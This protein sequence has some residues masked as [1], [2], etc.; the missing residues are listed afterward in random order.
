[1][2]G[3]FKVI[4]VVFILILL[5]G[6]FKKDD[7]DGV[8]KIELI[9]N[10]TQISADNNENVI[11]TIKNYDKDGNEIEAD[12]KLYKNGK[13]LDGVTFSTSEAGIYTFT[14]KSG[15][16]VSN[17]I[18]VSAIAPFEELYLISNESLDGTIYETTGNFLSTYVKLNGVNR[19]KRGGKGEKI[20][21]NP[22]LEFNAPMLNNYI[23]SFKKSIK[24][25]AGESKSFYIYNFQSDNMEKM[26]AKLKYIGNS[27]EVWTNDESL[28]NTEEAQKL[29]TEFDNVISPLVTQN[30]YTPSDIDGNGKVEIL[31]YDIKD[32]YETTGSYVGGYFY[33][34][35]LMN[36]Y[37]GNDMEIF[38]ID[39]YP[40]MYDS[41]NKFNIKYSYETLVH[42]F[43]HM[44]NF[45][46]VYFTD[47]K[48]SSVEPL[49]LNEGL[50][51]AA[52]QI[53][54]GSVLDYRINYY[55]H[56]P[57]GLIRDGY[58]MLDWNNLLEDYS[59]SYLFIQYIKEQT[60]MGDSALKE[61]FDDEN[62]NYKSIEKVAQKYIRSDITFGELMTDYRIAMLKKENS[63][64][65]G[66]NGTA[67]FEAINTPV[68][69]GGVKN[70][71]GG[72]AVVVP[73]A[74]VVSVPTDSGENI[75]YIKIT[76]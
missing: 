18:K 68:Y 70:I 13:V 45:N 52:E 48:S 49:W 14:A 26:S 28:I 55:N 38:Y 64:L 24:Y 67:G 51:Q 16:V 53:Y 44:V 12:S 3:K 29:A 31:C 54:R 57:E 76:K 33:D 7:K 19:L 4:S 36:S 69:S 11:F 6:C 37:Y 59:L 56:D 75:K 47:G 23:D 62:H 50:S 30:F 32:D 43:Q 41:N 73:I 17:E 1:M 34:A 2:K 39:T 60:G 65:Y 72:G 61:I 27:C 71:Y 35:D 66:F 8:A 21:I 9:S 46:K 74:N 20:K 15:N 42:E 63:G 58:S 5:F 40:A 22:Y 25:N 10:L